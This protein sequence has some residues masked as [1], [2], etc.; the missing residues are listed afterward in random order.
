MAYF[1]SSKNRALWKRELDALREERERRQRE[2]YT[3]DAQN[4]RTAKTAENPFRKKISFAELVEQEVEA[5]KT[6]KSRQREAQVQRR[7][8]AQVER[9]KEIKPR[10]LARGKGL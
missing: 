2:G 5:S 10:E 9:E 1:D 3:P 7:K 8:E 6:E 4:V